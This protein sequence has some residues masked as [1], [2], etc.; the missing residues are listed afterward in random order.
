[1]NIFSELWR[2]LKSAAYDLYPDDGIW[3]TAYLEVPKN[4]SHGD[5]STNISMII[6]SKNKGTNP[7][8]IAGKL[9]DAWQKVPYLSKI[10]IAGPGFINFTITNEKWHQALL[11]MLQD[12]PDFW[13]VNIGAGCKVNVEYVSANPTGPIH[14][15][16]ARGAVY[17]DALA[18]ILK[19]CGYEVTKE[20]YINDAGSQI[21]TVLDSALLRYQEHVT[22]Q[23]VVIPQGLY[24]GEYLKKTGCSLAE[25]FGNQL[26]AMPRQEAHKLIKQYVLDSMMDIIKHDLQLLGVY[27]DIF[28]SEQSLHDSGKIDKAAA[29]LT[30]KGLI[31]QGIVPP[32]KGKV[33]E[34]WEAKEQMLF[35]SS[36]YGDDQDRPVKKS[37]GSWTYLAADFAYVQDKIDRGFNILVYILGADHG[38]YVKRMEALVDAL[39][40]GAVQSDIRISQLVNF[41]KNGQPVKMSKRQGTFMTLADVVQEVGKDVVRF[42]M[43]TRR[44]DITLDFDF[45]LVKQQSKDNPVFYVQYAYVR[46]GSI[47]GRIKNTVPQ[48]YELVTN[49]EYNLALLTSDLEMQLIKNLANWPR[50]LASAAATRE[51]QKIAYYLIDLASE[52]HSMWN[53]GKENND[54]RFAIESDIKMTCA[55]LSL[56]FAL[57]KIIAAALDVIGITPIESM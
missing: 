16:H 53:F 6:A 1:M 8:E 27:H 25:K 52:F 2:D 19:Y 20:Y 33:Q 49:G 13:Q 31:Y 4:A 46:A 26:L 47:I 39:S 30:A 37:D 55:R 40:A 24:P 36:S 32:P 28:F 35:K 43:L 51:P 23:E 11:G 3:Q 22:G 7:R 21:D 50:I 57:R 38:G 41:V 18:N 9:I 10:D 45:D 29:K 34:D 15:G 17:G 48:S 56:V 44:N 42:M 5:I 12:K 14:I 54:Y